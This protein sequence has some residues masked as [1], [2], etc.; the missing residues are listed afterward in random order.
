M[1]GVAES[2]EQADCDRLYLFPL[3]LHGDLA[4]ITL[5]QWG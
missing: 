4:H 5:D 2:M 1:S 3:Q